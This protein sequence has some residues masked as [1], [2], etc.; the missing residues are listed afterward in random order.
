MNPLPDPV[1]PQL[2]PFYRGY[3]K[4]KCSAPCN[5]QNFWLN[6]HLLYRKCRNKKQKK[7]HWKYSTLKKTRI[8]GEHHREMSISVKEKNPFNLR[9]KNIGNTGFE[10][11][12]MSQGRQ[13]ATNEMHCHTD[14]KE[15]KNEDKLRK[16][17][18]CVHFFLSFSIV[19]LQ[20]SV[21]E[22]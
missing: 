17:S 10:D 1:F 2:L 11:N 19:K 15:C 13:A 9:K 18:F 3:M 12:F 20:K 4:N 7:I 6:R 5:M 16:K 14:N 8:Y 21:N 22:E